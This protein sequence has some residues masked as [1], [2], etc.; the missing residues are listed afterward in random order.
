MPLHDTRGAAS[1]TGFGFGASTGGPDWSKYAMIPYNVA[2]SNPNKI[3]FLNVATNTV[4]YDVSMPTTARNCVMRMGN[5]LVVGRECSFWV[6]DIRTNSIVQSQTTPFGSQ[7]TG[8][9]FKFGEDKFGIM[10]KIG[11]DFHIVTL[12]INPNGTTTQIAFNPTVAS[13]GSGSGFD[14]PQGAAIVTC[15]A[16]GMFQSFSGR[17]AFRSIYSYVG[18]NTVTVNGNVSISADGTSISLFNSANSGD[19]FSRPS[20]CSGN[21][22]AII[23]DMDHNSYYISTGIQSTMTGF[24]ATG[25][26]TPTN[27][28]GCGITQSSAFFLLG[29]DGASSGYIRR[30]DAGGGTSPL[31]FSV[32][33]NTFYGTMQMYGD[34]AFFAYNAPSG[35][36]VYRTYSNITDT[37]SS[38]I[39]PSGINGYV[40]KSGTVY[41]TYNY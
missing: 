17:V 24:T 13:W 25:S 29:F 10:T 2:D 36:A 12:K 26:G 33:A 34:G 30:M 41:G 15:D 23:Y 4:D 3:G 22:R 31:G 8:D 11:M 19:N 1:A 39:V 40:N 14:S 37:F 21:G 32:L 6:I 9:F 16:K 35:T 5:Y 38:E 28:R 18:G 7:E 20:A 27:F